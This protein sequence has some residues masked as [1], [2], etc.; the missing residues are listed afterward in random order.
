[1]TKIL[2]LLVALTALFALGGCASYSELHPTT[3]SRMLTPAEE[4]YW[5][6]R[7]WRHD[8]ADE[9]AWELERQSSERMARN[10]R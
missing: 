3:E 1:M 6:D 10:F 8:K 9:W 5:L 7:R 2:S 4:A